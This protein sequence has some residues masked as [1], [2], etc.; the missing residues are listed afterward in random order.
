MKVKISSRSLLISYFLFFFIL[1]VVSFLITRIAPTG[2]FYTYNPTVFNL[3]F[4][5]PPTIWAAIFGMGGLLI[6]LVFHDFK[7]LSPKFIYGLMLLSVLVIFAVFCGLPYLMEPNPRNGDSWVHGGTAN[8]ILSTGHLNLS[9]FQ[10]QSY[11]SS[12]LILSIQSAIS[13]V[14][15]TS[16]LHILPMAIV[17]VFFAALFVAINEISKNPKIAIVSVLVFGLSTY[18]LQFNFAPSLFGWILLFLLI[19]MFAKTAQASTEFKLVSNKLSFTIILLL[20]IIGVITTHP[21]TQFSAIAIMFFL[22]IFRKKIWRSNYAFLFSLLLLTI[23]IITAWA[24]FFGFSYF[25]NVLIE[26]RNAFETIVSNLSKSV[27]AQSFKGF[28]PFGVANL[29]LARR[30]IFILIPLAGLCGLILMWKQQKTSKNFTFLLAILFAGLTEI[31]LTLFGVLPLERSIQLAFIPLSVFSA[32]LI[33]TKKKVGVTILIFL[34]LTIPI[35]FA[36]NYWN[37]PFTMTFNWEISSAK[38]AANYFHGIV[39]ADYTES[40]IMNYYGNFSKVY[41]DYYAIGAPPDVFNQ[42]FIAA[43]GIKLVCITQLDVLNQA[44]EGYNLSPTFLENSTFDL[45]YNNGYSTIQVNS[46]QTPQLNIN[47]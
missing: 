32:Y 35:N 2:P 25:S 45:V 19:A 30:A 34:V 44:L 17:L 21:V 31:P 18:Y 9:K 33:C 46:A 15:L 47:P 7:G 22:F 14:N 38:F 41:N 24:M 43:H 20:F 23:L 8:A 26:S 36:A 10:Y 11:P 16:L 27:V 12:F 1:T 5:M 39:L 37:E 13:G 42:N 40:E 28:T 29:L 4:Y 3:F 6:F